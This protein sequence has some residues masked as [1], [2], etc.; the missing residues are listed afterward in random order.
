MQLWRGLLEGDAEDG[1]WRCRVFYSAAE[2]SKLT[3]RTQLL[4]VLRRRYN[5]QAGIVFKCF[6]IF[7][8]MKPSG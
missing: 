5:L 8:Q 2:Q 3:E 4:C 1:L 7:W 6:H